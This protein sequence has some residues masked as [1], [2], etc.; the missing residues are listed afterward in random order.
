MKETKLQ[1]NLTHIMVFL[2]I[3][4]FCKLI[5][6]YDKLELEPQNIN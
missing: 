5:E 2:I 4:L 1:L 6:E 3:S